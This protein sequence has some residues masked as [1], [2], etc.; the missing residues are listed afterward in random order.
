MR[1]RLPLLFTIIALGGCTALKSTVHLAQA[2]QALVDARGRNAQN[3]AVYEYTMAIRYLEKAREENGSADYRVAE[4]LA[5][6][7]VEWAD[8][9][10]IAIEGGRR[11]VDVLGDDFGE[12]PTAVPPS[13]VFPD[14]AD[15]TAAPLE[16]LDDGDVPDTAPTG[17]T[18]G[19]E[20]DLDDDW[21]LEN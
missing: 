18:P 14:G 10:I 20:F 9:A 19:D 7:S 12:L 16:P 4:N 6:R 5:K 2:E 13:E 3:L 21:D 15:E 1:L 11:G 8:K 17:P